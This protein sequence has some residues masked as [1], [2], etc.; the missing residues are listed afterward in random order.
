[1][2]PSKMALLY[3]YTRNPIWC[4]AEFLILVP[5]ILTMRKFCRL[6][7]KCRLFWSELPLSGGAFISLC[8]G[9]LRAGI[10]PTRTRICQ[11]C[12]SHFSRTVSFSYFQN[13]HFTIFG[14]HLSLSR[15][16][17]WKVVGGLEGGWGLSSR[18]FT[19]AGISYSISR[20]QTQR[21][22]RLF[23]HPHFLPEPPS[24]PLLP[25]PPITILPLL[26]PF[27]TSAYQLNRKV[28]EFFQSSMNFSYQ[29]EWS[30][31]LSNP[32]PVATVRKY[33]RVSGQHWEIM[34]YVER[35][36][37]G[38][39]TSLAHWRNQSQSLKVSD[40]SRESEDSF[41]I[42]QSLSKS[43]RP[44]FQ[45]FKTSSRVYTQIFA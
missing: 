1:M 26:C 20:H 31:P 21:W 41:R 15:G 6:S 17:Q 16:L 12:F 42:F 13:S 18:G 19:M 3:I 39:K 22:P 11:L 4:P 44:V 24:P 38:R 25:Q 27:C 33:G 14:P 30:Q 9:W 43:F 5:P 32:F 45:S 35:Y 10:N 23:L 40:S 28:L 34:E 7:G 36:K 29:L 8:R 37:R 2:H